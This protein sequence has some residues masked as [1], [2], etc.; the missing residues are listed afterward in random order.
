MH[1]TIIAS[2]DVISPTV[3]FGFF[4]FSTHILS[5]MLTEFTIITMVMAKS[6]T[7]RRYKNGQ[8]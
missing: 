3:N 5:W 7:D 1:V 6:R 2:G 8:K 4:C